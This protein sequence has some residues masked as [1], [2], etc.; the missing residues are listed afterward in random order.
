M[1]VT[2][3][4]L[5]NERIMLLTINDPWAI[6][7]LMDW[8]PI[9]QPYFD[10]ATG[11]VHTII[12]LSS[13]KTLPSGVL[14]GRHSPNME[15]PSGGFV[16]AVGTSGVV[17]SIAEI[18]FQLSRNNRLKFMSDASQAM[19]FLKKQIETET[20]GKLQGDRHD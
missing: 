17:R 1:P 14:K 15:H 16:V 4:P 9:M 13:T 7:E 18:A 2:F 10:R 6:E 3:A 11:K 5:E 19:T 8:Y 12:D 20:S